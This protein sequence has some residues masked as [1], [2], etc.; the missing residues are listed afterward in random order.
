MI[1]RALDSVRDVLTGWAKGRTSLNAAA[2]DFAISTSVR[3][4]G[5]DA[6]RTG[7]VLSTA[8]QVPVDD[9]LVKVLRDFIFQLKP[10]CR[11]V[12]AEW[13]IR[14]GFRFPAAAGDFIEWVDDHNRRKLGR[15]YGLNTLL[16]TAT[17]I[18]A[19]DE[20]AEIVL[21]EQV[22]ANQTHGLLGRQTPILGARYEDACA[23][24]VAV[25][26]GN[27]APEPVSA[28]SGLAAASH[29]GVELSRD[30][31]ERVQHAMDEQ[32]LHAEQHI[33]DPRVT[34]RAPFEPMVTVSSIDEVPTHI[35][36]QPAC[37]KCHDTGWFAD[38]RIGGENLCDCGAPPP[39]DIA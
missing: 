19:D 30:L 2:L 11:V 23:A 39:P 26:S 10:A 6:F 36:P 20:R 4:A 37:E 5:F 7:L 25:A 15:V 1:G 12:T 14:T 29:G 35:E 24:Q 28:A 18:R 22:V 17:V 9:D 32:R 13:V 38:P 33:H 34:I 31:V 21:G 16:A 27:P 3:R 8:F